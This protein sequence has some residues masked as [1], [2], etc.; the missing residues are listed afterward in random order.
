MALLYLYKQYHRESIWARPVRE[1]VLL[2]EMASIAFASSPLNGWLIITIEWMIDDSP[3]SKQR[4]VSINQSVNRINHDSQVG[5][6]LES[7][8]E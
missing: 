5:C 6:D 7:S 8:G 1:E 3:A 4:K 2:L